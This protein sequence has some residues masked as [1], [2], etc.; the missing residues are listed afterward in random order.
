M[1]SAR[2]VFVAL[3]V[4]VSTACDGLRHPLD[5]SETRPG[6]QELALEEAKETLDLIAG[7]VMDGSLYVTEE[8]TADDGCATA[9]FG[10]SQGDVGR[11]LIRAYT[12][13]SMALERNPES[14]LD[15]YER[16]W[17]QRDESVTRSSPS[18][19][20]G[21]VARVDGIGYELV[22]LPPMMELRAYIPCY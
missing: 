14:L 20:P 10:A 15:D 1:T 8:W 17:A 11:V 4:L 5:D 22:S 19:D 2:I 3:S 21:A 9:P 18:M 6:S 7:T 16:F 12:E 13:E